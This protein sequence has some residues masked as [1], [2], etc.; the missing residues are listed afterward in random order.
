MLRILALDHDNQLVVNPDLNELHA[1]KWYWVDFNM[2]TEEESALLNSHFHFH[3]LAIEDCMLELQRPK[4]DYYEN[5]S[6]LVLHAI[7]AQTLEACEIDLFISENYIVSFH[8]H[9]LEELDA[10]WEI[11]QQKNDAFKHSPQ[12]IGYKII[13]KIVDAFFPV[14]QQ[15]EDRL[16]AIENSDEVKRGKDT[17]ITKTYTVRKDLLKLR[18]TI[19]PMRDLIYRILESKRFII[20]E[21][22]RAYFQDIYDHLLKLSEMIESNRQLTADIRDNYISMNSFRMNNIMKTLT[23]I[24]TIFMPLTFLAGI[25]G[26]NFVNMPELN[27]HYGYFIVLGIMAIG[28]IAMFLWFKAKGWFDSE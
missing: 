24:T 14:V 4:L 8:F 16:L 13:D 3:P 17:V 2:P 21:Q 19:L 26:M 23:V 5:L 20:Q 1:M 18:Q 15:I 22:K 9:Q 27:W 12:E 28:G 10:T 11:F 25:Y 7:H 6:F